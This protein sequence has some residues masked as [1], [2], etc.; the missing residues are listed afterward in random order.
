MGNLFDINGLRVAITGGGGVL[1]GGVAQ[2]LGSLG[3]EVAVLDLKQEAA[4]AVSDAITEKGGKAIA[5]AANV[6]ERDS[7]EAA[8]EACTKAF[9]GIDALVNG[10]GGNHPAATTSPDKRFFDLPIEAFQQ[11][12]NLNLVGTVLPSMVFGRAMAEQKTG[13]I[14]NVASMNA[15]KPL[16]RIPAYSAAKGGVKNFTEWLSVHMAQEYSPDIRVNA[17]APGFFLTHQNRFLLTDEKTGDLTSR[18][19]SIVSH[20]PMGRFGAPEDLYGTVVWL[21]SPAS[22][23]ISGVTVPIDGGY[24]AFGGV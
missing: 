19:Q 7:L 8:L 1:C 23:F 3:A 24:S 21:I 22:A 15:L 18:G 4:A 6:L 11:V 12:M 14:L 10:A 5:V 13:V 2:H 20:T 9:G 17:I 16:T